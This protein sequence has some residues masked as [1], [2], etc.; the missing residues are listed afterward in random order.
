MAIT[1]D[2]VYWIQQTFHWAPCHVWCFNPANIS[3]AQWKI[4]WHPALRALG[5]EQGNK[6]AIFAE[7][8]RQ[9]LRPIIRF[10]W[11]LDGKF[12]DPSSFLE[13]LQLWPFTSYSSN[14]L[15]SRITPFMVYVYIMPLKWP[16]IAN[17]HGVTVS[18]TGESPV[19]AKLADILNDSFMGITPT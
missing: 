18:P 16:I 2:S 15:T 3:K 11:E 1:V 13:I 6:I 4:F 7:A 17:S 12:R 8:S 9:K 14:E 10:K 5:Q 19:T